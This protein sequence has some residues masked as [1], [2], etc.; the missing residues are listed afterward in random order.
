VSK[1]QITPPLT[2]IP[3]QVALKEMCLHCFVAYLTTALM[4]LFEIKREKEVKHFS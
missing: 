4:M 1:G 2:V 3:G